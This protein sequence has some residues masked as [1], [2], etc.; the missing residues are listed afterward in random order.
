MSAL[1]TEARDWAGRGQQPEAALTQRAA[2]GLQ[3]TF[4]SGALS[5]DSSDEE[6]GEE[7]EDRVHLAAALGHCSVTQRA[8]ACSVQ[9]TFEVGRFG[10]FSATRDVAMMLCRAFYVS[11]FKASDACVCDAVEEGWDSFP[12]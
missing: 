6:L 10:R 4:R 7:A 1:L 12:S 11:V 3:M 8:V 9:E 5:E 2:Q